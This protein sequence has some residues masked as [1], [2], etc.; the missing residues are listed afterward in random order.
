MPCIPNPL[1]RR[2]AHRCLNPRAGSS[3][4]CTVARHPATRLPERWRL[5]GLTMRPACITHLTQR[6]SAGGPLCVISETTGWAGGRHSNCFFQPPMTRFCPIWRFVSGF[7]PADLGGG[8]RSRDGGG[9][10]KTG[11]WNGAPSAELVGRRHDMVR[12]FGR[13]L[14]RTMMDTVKRQTA[15]DS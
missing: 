4:P 2:L 10:G 11:W 7:R 9:S 12:P 13:D 6:T 3:S 8:G 5:E 14:G 15:Q 1:S